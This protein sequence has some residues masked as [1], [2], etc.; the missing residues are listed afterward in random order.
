MSPFEQSIIEQVKVGNPNRLVKTARKQHAK[1][2]NSGL[3]FNSKS[4][5]IAKRDAQLVNTFEYWEFITSKRYPV[6]EKGIYIED[7]LE[8]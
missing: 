3:I 8:D 5:E 1:T 4:G 2:G 7:R 6:Y